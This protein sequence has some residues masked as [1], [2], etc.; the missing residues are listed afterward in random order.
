MSAKEQTEN[1]WNPLF[2]LRTV[3]LAKSCQQYSWPLANKNNLVCKCTDLAKLQDFPNKLP[4]WRM[5]HYLVSG[6]GRGAVLFLTLQSMSFPCLIWVLTFWEKCHF[7]R[8]SILFRS[9]QFDFRSQIFKYYLTLLV[10]EFSTLIWRS[11]W[12][13]ISKESKMQ[14]SCETQIRKRKAFPV[15]GVRCWD[16]F[17]NSSKIVNKQVINHETFGFQTR[18]IICEAFVQPSQ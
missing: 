1:G 18:F 10:R 9:W 2:A 16:S 4:T 13:L 8:L 6:W 7:N 11:F 3:R 14:Y 5:S 12:F 15:L 17:P